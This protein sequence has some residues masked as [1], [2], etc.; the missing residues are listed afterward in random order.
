M[1]ASPP[2]HSSSFILHPFPIKS[3]R[4]LIKVALP[5]DAINEALLE[6]AKAI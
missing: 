4:K 2:F 3:L 1:A 6:R 5:L